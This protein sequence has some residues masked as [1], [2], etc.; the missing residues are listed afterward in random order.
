MCLSRCLPSQL[1]SSRGSRN[2]PG[3][4]PEAGRDDHGKLAGRTGFA[5]QLVGGD[6]VIALNGDETFPM[7]S[8]Y[9]VA[10]AGKVLAMVDKGEVRLEQMVV[11]PP[12]ATCRRR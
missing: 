8:A 11:V 9:K 7:A 1:A 10:I 5:A 3:Q 12:K 2:R 4:A 6:T